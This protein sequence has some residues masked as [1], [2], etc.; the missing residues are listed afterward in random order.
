MSARRKLRIIHIADESLRP[1]FSNTPPAP[2]IG[3]SP[4]DLRREISNRNL[5]LAEHLPH[6]STY[7]ELP[8]I[9]YQ[10][11]DGHHGNFLAASYRRIVLHR[12]GAGG[13]RSVTRQIDACREPRIANG[14]SWIAPTAQ[15]R[16]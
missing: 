2:R 12:I 14:A 8:S 7:G 11:T 10:D 6:E 4:S 13:S 9:L 5:E 1:E 15:T 16:C 3:W